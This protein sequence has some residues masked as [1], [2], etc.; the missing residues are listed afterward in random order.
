M[1][2]QRSP[3]SIAELV[4]LDAIL[5]GKDF[6]AVRKAGA[7]DRDSQS[8]SEVVDVDPAV[9]REQW[10]LREDPQVSA[11]SRLLQGSLHSVLLQ[12]PLQL[13]QVIQGIFIVGVDGDP[14]G[15][16]RSRIDGIDGD[17][18][19]ALKVLPNDGRCKPDR[20]AVFPA[21]GPVVVMTARLRMWPG[22]L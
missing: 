16:L 15:T 9:S 19:C 13:Q 2:S 17:C 12:F 21:L 22:R 11:A 3:K 1:Y 8:L 14:L 10:P 5:A 20:T 18:D 4:G 7:L 6:N